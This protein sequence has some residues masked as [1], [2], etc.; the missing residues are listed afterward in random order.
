MSEIKSGLYDKYLYKDGKKY[1]AQYCLKEDHIYK[2]IPNFQRKD[3]IKYISSYN[4]LKN[5]DKKE[6]P[7]NYEVPTDEFLIMDNYIPL[8]KNIGIHFEE[9]TINKLSLNSTNTFKYLPLK[10]VGGLYYDKETKLICKDNNEDIIAL[11]INYAEKYYNAKTVEFLENEIFKKGKYIIVIEPNYGIFESLKSDLDMIRIS[12][13][14]EIILLKNEE[15]LYYVLDRTRNISAENYRLLGNFMM[16]NSMYEKAIYYYTTA[17]K[18]NKQNNDDNLDLI[19]HSNLSEAYNRYGYYSKVVYYT[20]YSLNKINKLI[21]DKS[22]EKNSFLSEQ[23]IKALYKKTKALISLRKFKEAYDILFDKSENN[24]NNDIMEDFLKLE[25]VKEMLNIVKEGY[26][27]TLGHFD[28][29]KMINEEKISFDFKKYGDYLNPKIEINFQKGKGIK[30]IAK[31]K[32]NTGE[33]L[34]AE[35]ALSFSQYRDENYYDDGEDDKVVSTDNPK[36][37]VEIELFN[38]FCLKLKKAPLDNEKFYMLCDGRNLDED[39]NERKK[40]C[41]EQDKGLRSLELFKINQTIC[42]NKY[43][44][45][46]NILIDKE[47]GVGVWGYASLFN[48]DCLPNSTYFSIGDF[49]FGYCIREI[50]KGEE[51]TSR[52]V[53]SRKS[54][55]DRQQTLLENWRFNCQC[56]LCQYQ[57]KKNDKEYDNYMEIMDKSYKQISKEIAKKFEEFLEQNKRKYNC[58]EMAKAYLRLE[59]YYGLIHDYAETKKFSKLVTKYAKDKNFSFQKDNLF[60]LMLC[61]SG[62]NV[63]HSE[64]VSIYNEIINLLEKYTPFNN[65][66]IQYLFRNFMAK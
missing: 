29:I 61:A 17:I 6:I 63:N 25:Q 57:S 10:I 33:L 7:K 55:K 46:R 64:F 34:I 50:D 47:L 3:K 66:E 16:R 12:S 30:M 22:K 20:D 11:S 40:Y 38:K 9:I 42:L 32:I 18:I 65:M 58:Y 35:K 41:E 28:Y 8:G 15:E 60:K 37:I 39:L 1:I 5:K 27:N 14:N 51:I 44:S 26:E 24:P 59:E 19:L 62:V 4:S 49:Y 36:V 54:Y 13:P 48:H 31:E 2:S 53:S 23:K 52:Y 56:Q 45:G 43:G 21:K